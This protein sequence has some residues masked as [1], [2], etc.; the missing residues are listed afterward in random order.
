VIFLLG[1]AMQVSSAVKPFFIYIRSTVLDALP[2]AFI[3][4]IAH[5]RLEE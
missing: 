3:L 4:Y 5:S 2:L 1:T